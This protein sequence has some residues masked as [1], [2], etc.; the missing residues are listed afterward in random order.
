MR[1]VL[2]VCR[3][4]AAVALLASNF[5]AISILAADVRP[6]DPSFGERIRGLIVRVVRTL[7][8]NLSVPPPQP[9]G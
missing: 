3:R 7:S 6:R 4:G 9:G 8:D 5:F 1:S 2:K